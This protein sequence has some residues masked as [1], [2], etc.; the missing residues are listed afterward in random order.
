MANIRLLILGGYGGTGRSLARELLRHTLFDLVIAGRSLEKAQEFC[1]QLRSDYPEREIRAVQ[2]DASDPGRL[3]KAFRDIDLVVVTATVPD[4]MDRIGESALDSGS[5]CLD[6]LMRSQVVELLRPL[7]ER[8]REEGRRF[9]TQAGFH[10]GLVAPLIRYAATHFDRYDRAEVYLAMNAVFERPESTHEIIREVGENNSLLMEAGKWRRAGY[11]DARK[12]DFSGSMGTRL[13][14]PLHLIEIEP[15][16]NLGLRE[17][18]VYSAGFNWF[19][20]NVVFSLAYML[21]SLR[22]GLGVA[23]CG[24]LMHWG[25]KRFYQGR[26]EVE[27]RLVARGRTAG[28]EQQCELSLYSGDPYALTAQSVI[29]CLNQYMDGTISQPGLHLM[30]LALEPARA[31]GDLSAMGVTVRSSIPL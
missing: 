3:R 6:I 1:N 24:R 19:T 9:I 31:L 13:C 18:G 12:F 21:Q 17:I 2:V 27:L 28:G 5:D 29:S 20:D 8:I 14:Y 16:A 26:P 11:R 4:L 7:E 30:G 22:K 15:L 23:F 25:V 10:P